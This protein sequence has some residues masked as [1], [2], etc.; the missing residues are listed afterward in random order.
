MTAEII[1]RVM[2]RKPIVPEYEVAFMPAMAEGEFD[3][4]HMP[5]EKLDQRFD[6]GHVHRDKGSAQETSRS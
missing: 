4:R 2:Q 5:V 3:P 6:H 1:Y